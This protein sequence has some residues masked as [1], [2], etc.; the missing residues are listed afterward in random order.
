[1]QQDPCISPHSCVWSLRRRRSRRWLSVLIPNDER[2]IISLSC[3]FKDGAFYPPFFLVVRFFFF[4][5][6]QTLCA[7][8]WRSGSNKRKTKYALLSLAVSAAN[9]CDWRFLGVAYP[10]D[11]SPNL[12]EDAALGSF[13]FLSLPHSFFPPQVEGKKS[14]YIKKKEF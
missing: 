12:F 7:Q 13:Y 6:F 14:L 3:P 2:P 4:F 5:I 8:R 9:Y 11:A 10:Q 1:M